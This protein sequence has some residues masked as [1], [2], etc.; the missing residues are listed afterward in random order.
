MLVRLY[1]QNFRSLKDAFELSLV[2][3]ELTNVADEGR[4]TFEVPI[5]GMKA[6]LRL[7][8]TLAIY[9]PNASGKS[10]VLIAGRAIAWLVL[11]SSKKSSPESAIPPYEPFVLDDETDSSPIELACDVI[12]QDSIL[13]YSVSYTKNSFV[14]EKLS[15]VDGEKEHVLIDR[16]A[17]GEIVG[18]LI[19]NSDAN[20]LYVQSM[21]PNV[22]VIS[23]LAQH[24]PSTGGDSVIK[25]Y[26]AIVSAL[27]YE[28]YT[29]TE[30]KFNR[31]GFEKISDNSEY[32]EW[33][34]KHLIQ[35]ADIGICDLETEREKVEYPDFVKEAVAKAEEDIQLPESQV[36]V[37]FVHSGRSNR[38]IEFAD[39]STGTKKLLSIAD[40]WWNLANV[41]STLLADELGAS[42]HPKLFDR[43]V[44][45]V[46]DPP[47]EAVRS[48]LV[49]TAH[50]TGLLESMD[51]RPPALLRDQVYFTRKNTMGCTELYPLT[52]FKNDARTVHN[53]RK[54]YMS[55]LYGALPAVERLSL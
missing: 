1:G 53:L 25:Y 28:D 38:P 41:G 11:Y 29:D 20:K 33:I 24:G 19:S 21:Q 4:G 26:N 39:E 42:L 50:E 14:Y 37:S 13:R 45:A 3:A 35:G 49:F 16:N 30:S 18:E 15:L 2:A 7:L 23:K 27:N 48:Q 22:A 32:R 31:Q 43:I 55:G 36:V 47:S 46:N 8:R 17:K 40:D 12:Y 51:G 54:R 44:R 6:P 9:G 10:T 34:M 5:K 52:D